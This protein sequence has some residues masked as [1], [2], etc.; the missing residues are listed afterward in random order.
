MKVAVLPFLVA[1]T[2]SIAST[3]YA[4]GQTPRKPTD[5]ST[6]FTYADTMLVIV[7]E[8]GAAAVRVKPSEGN[9]CAYE[10]RFE[11]RGT[12]K[13]ETGQG[14]LYERRDEKGVMGG[15]VHIEAGPFR[16]M[17]SRHSKTA[18][19]IYYTPE[20]NYVCLA[21]PERFH[22]VVIRDTFYPKLDLQRFIK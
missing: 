2:M 6:I 4:R 13:P 8:K 12:T 19:W 11:T 22:D 21:D 10:Y 14:K 17:W 9:E 16:L 20:E 3:E 18:G 1:A 5:I 7:S 15:A